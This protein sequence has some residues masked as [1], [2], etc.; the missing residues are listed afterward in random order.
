[1]S[2]GQFT[3][4]LGSLFAAGFVLCAGACDGE[5]RQ[6]DESETSSSSDD[7][8]T[9]GEM[10]TGQQYCAELADEGACYG[11]SFEQIDLGDGVGNAGGC[12]WVREVT[13]DEELCTPT[14]TEVS[15]CAY[16]FGPVAG[17]ASSCSTEVWPAAR[18]FVKDDPSG[19]SVLHPT[20]VA[21][22]TPPE[23]YE[24]CFDASDTSTLCG[25][26][27]NALFGPP[28]TG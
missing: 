14:G 17:D 8:S 26:A 28:N 21:D 25:C 3:R 2:K 12:F 6:G 1:M 22:P 13:F 18:L 27:C 7:D 4:I 19:S 9:G 20:G 11:F 5:K 16:Y 23:G 10:K 15:R 24:N